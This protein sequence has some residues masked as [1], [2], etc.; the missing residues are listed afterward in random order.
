MGNRQGC[1]KRSKTERRRVWVAGKNPT[2][3]EDVSYWCQKYIYD[4]KVP[5]KIEASCNVQK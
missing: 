4:A 2:S 1:D 5:E 3:Y